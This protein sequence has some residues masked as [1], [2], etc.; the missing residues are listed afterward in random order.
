MA[1]KNKTTWRKTIRT[2]RGVAFD[3]DGVFTDN[4]V[5]IT[6][7]GTESVRCC[8]SDG[9]GLARLRELGVAAVI[10]SSEKNPAVVHR[11]KK[12]QV[13]C[14]H[15]VED[16]LAALR[17]W[18]RDEGLSLDTLAF[19]GNDINDA[20]CLRAV[21]LPVVVSDAW[22][23]VKPLAALTL[24]RKGGEGAVREFCD[25]VWTSQGEEERGR[26]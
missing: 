13:A 6:E 7:D 4:R 21:G 2:L 12:L 18:A 15:G 3:F 1:R 5:L 10:L 23:E 26:I 22:P 20:A 9:Y 14:R 25:L 8:R 19:L 24:Q 17:E 11:A 16:K